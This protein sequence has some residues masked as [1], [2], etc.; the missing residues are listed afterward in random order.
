MNT[1]EN[2]LSVRFVDVPQTG[3]D[4]MSL[5]RATASRSSAKRWRLCLLY[6][7]HLHLT[8]PPT[9]THTLSEHF[10]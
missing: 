10:K 3:V 5:T 4:E 2:A 7:V 1:E 6:Y 8:P 9:H